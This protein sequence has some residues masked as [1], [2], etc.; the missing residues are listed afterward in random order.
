MN[1]NANADINGDNIVDV[2]DAM[3]LA[4]NYGNTA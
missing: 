3:L 2:Y 1:W 4:S